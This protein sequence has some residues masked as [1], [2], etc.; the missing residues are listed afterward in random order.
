M[1]LLFSS[2]FL[3][4][5]SPVKSLFFSPF[6]FWLRIAHHYDVSHSMLTRISK[7][8]VV[9]TYLEN[10]V[11][12]KNFGHPQQSTLSDLGGMCLLKKARACASLIGSNGLDLSVPSLWLTMVTTILRVIGH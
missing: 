11:G 10:S 9:V 12:V 1:Q 5:F 4:F 7:Q 8:S 6:L 2:L 3:F